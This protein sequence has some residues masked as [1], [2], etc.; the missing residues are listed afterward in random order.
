MTT[1]NPITLTDV[2]HSGADAPLHLITAVHHDLAD[3]L[4]ATAASIAALRSRLPTRRIRWHV[5]VDGPGDLRHPIPGTDTCRRAARSIGVSA[6]R[7]AALTEA[8]GEGG[9]VF[10]VD[11]DD[12]I[13]P[14]GWADL[15][16]DPDFATT[17]WVATNL[18]TCDGQ[19]TP[20]WFTGRRR[21]HIGEAADTWTTPMAFHPNNIVVDASLALA[22]GG[23]PAM[24]VNED[25]AYAFAI[26][27]LSE[28]I[29]LPHVTLRYRKW[30]HQTVAGGTYLRDKADAFAHIAAVTN[31]RRAHT[32]LPPVTAPAVLPGSL[33]LDDNRG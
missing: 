33:Y 12:L 1:T 19:P 13:N 11:G 20:H 7:N 27:D 30:E 25:I 15:L 21:W 32:G 8:A 9:W 10:R 14:D 2:D 28:G 29:G 17:P 22:I 16:A 18:T 6:A 26:N 5:T 4:P 3:H 31:A 23:W 24:G